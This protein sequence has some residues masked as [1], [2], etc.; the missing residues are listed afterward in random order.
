MVTSV[1]MALDQ[2]L[3]VR[4]GGRCRTG[5]HPDLRE[6]IVDVAG[7]RLFGQAE[8]LRDGAVGLAACDQPQHLHLA[9]GQAAGCLTVRPTPEFESLDE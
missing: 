5:R 6:A 8:F 3:L 9:P 7:N 1:Y 4:V 2:A